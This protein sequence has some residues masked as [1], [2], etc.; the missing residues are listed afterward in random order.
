MKRNSHEQSLHPTLSIYCRI[1][2]RYPV[3]KK[4]TNRRAH[5]HTHARSKRNCKNK[6]DKNNDNTSEHKL[7]E[8]PANQYTFVI[9][10]A[11]ISLLLFLHYIYV[12]YLCVC[13]LF[14]QQ[15]GPTS[16]KRVKK[17]AELCTLFSFFLLTVKLFFSNFLNITVIFF[18]SYDDYLQPTI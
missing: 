6:I 16:N 10:V 17:E 7:Q 12:C 15:R 14:C 9:P 3:K 18:Y 2:P 13:V 5:T 1:K 11:I 4:N 8:I